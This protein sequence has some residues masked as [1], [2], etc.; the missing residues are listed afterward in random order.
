[1]SRPRPDAYNVSVGPKE[2]I[3]EL[4]ASIRRA[5]DQY[6][7]LGHSDLSDADYRRAVIRSR[8]SQARL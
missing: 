4:H 8:H 7:N 6:Y 3:A 2:R 1:L 5:D